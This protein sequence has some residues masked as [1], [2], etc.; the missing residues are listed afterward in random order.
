ML[1]KQNPTGLVPVLTEAAASINLPGLD[2]AYA[3]FVRLKQPIGMRSRSI[4]SIDYR[5]RQ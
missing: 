5:A 4:G 2:F 3:S 1:V